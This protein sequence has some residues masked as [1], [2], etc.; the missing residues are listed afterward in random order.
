MKPEPH[1][2]KRAMQIV[3]SGQ[4]V[5]V[6]LAIA[7]GVA[8]GA[9]LLPSDG[10]HRFQLAKGTNF[11]NLR[12]IYERTHYDSKPID[13][14]LLG[15]SRT[16]LGLSAP[17]LQ[18][19][20]AQRG[21]AASVENFAVIAEGRNLQ[22]EIVRELLSVKAPRLIVLEVNEEPFP[23][24]HPGYKYVATDAD[25]WG[26][27]GRGLHDALLGLVYL[28]YRNLVLLAASI[29]PETL[30]QSPSFNPTKYAGAN[31]DTTRSH[32]VA[33]GEFIDMDRQVSVASLAAGVRDYQLRNA[34]PRPLPFADRVYGDDTVFARAIAVAAAARGIKIAFI[35]L[36]YYTGPA[37]VAKRGF[38]ASFGPM[39]DGSFIRTHDKLYE[40]WSHLNHAGAEVMTDTL[41]AGIAPSLAGQKLK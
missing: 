7:A 22:W 2:R 1:F 15:S 31:I 23:Y 16:Q 3:K 4:A 5:A 11:D 27:A 12:W 30:G 19:D 29:F 9:T 18:T 40:N 34:P 21:I 24:G 38:Y 13:V 28:P 26:Q 10:Y 20:L 37:S 33:T 8:L 36:P 6:I 32:R 35:Y 14:V 25:L 41:A 39:I 17:R